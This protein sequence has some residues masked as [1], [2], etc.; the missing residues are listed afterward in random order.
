MKVLLEGASFTGKSTIA[1]E[2]CKS[3]DF[4]RCDLTQIMLRKNQQPTNFA[5][6]YG[7]YNVFL[8]D[9]YDEV[10][11]K[12][13]LNPEKHLLIVRSWPSVLAHFHLLGVDV[14]KDHFVRAV[15]PDVIVHLFA[16]PDRRRARRTIK[17]R[18]SESISQPFQVVSETDNDRL[19]DAFATKA[20]RHAE[21]PIVRCSTN[22]RLPSESRSEIRRHMAALGMFA[23]VS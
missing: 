10:T 13:E 21:C 11:L 14:S 8:R 20:Y 22:N 5:R 19:E 7:L 1:D 12:Q 2:F 23:P 6:L 9:Q 18:D 17:S 3:D 15:E 16:H 4:I